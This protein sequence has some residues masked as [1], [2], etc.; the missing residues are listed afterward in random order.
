MLPI[1]FSENIFSLGLD[2]AQSYGGSLSQRYTSAT[3]YPHIVIDNFLPDSVINWLSDSFPK[4]D[5]SKDRNF[6]NPKVEFRKRQV[7]WESFI[8]EHLTFFGF[9]NS[10]PVLKFLESL[11][12][13]PGLIGDPY[14]A[15][16]GFH[17]I[18]TGGRLGLHADFRIHPVLKCQRRLNLLIY[19]N[20]DWDPDFGGELEIWDQ[21]LQ[22]CCHAIAPLFNRAVVFNTDERSYHGHPEPLNCPEGITRR[23]VAL[24]YYTAEVAEGTPANGTMFVPKPDDPSDIKEHAFQVRMIQHLKDEMTRFQPTDEDKKKISVIAQI[25]Q[26]K[27]KIR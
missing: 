12:G 16:G 21:N 5:P 9:M 13:I 10:A 4:P 1:H 26:N 17:E 18:S 8:P 11:T 23:S 14:F 7:L 6:L 24:Y 20:K 27:V 15:G 25:V 22:N 19:L 3:P 2:D